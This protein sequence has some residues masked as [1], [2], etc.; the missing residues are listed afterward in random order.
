SPLPG[1]LNTSKN[2]YH[3]RYIDMKPRKP[4]TEL[5]R[6]RSDVAAKVRELRKARR[7]TQAE[8]GK[9][10]GLSQARL[11]EIEGGDGSFTAEQLLT[12]LALF[13]VSLSE[14]VP[15]GD[16]EDDLQNALVRHGAAQL[17]TVPGVEPTGRFRDPADAIVAVLLDP[18]S[19]RLVTALAPVIAQN[20]DR[21]SL[22]VLRARLSAAGREG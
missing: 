8:L 13:N 21:L 15:D 5:D 14:F 6:R 9:R 12:L 10:L 1:L 22:P 4:A 7:W 18:R 2:R 17:R 19:A 11:S 20:V 16:V 3:Y